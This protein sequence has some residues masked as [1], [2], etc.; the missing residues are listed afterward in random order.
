VVKNDDLR[1]YMDTSDEWIFTRTGVK[2]RRY[3]EV[4]V[5]T[6]DLALEASRMAIKD[7]GLA[8]GD[9]ECIVLATL[10]PDRLFPGTAIYLQNKLG[11]ADKCCACYDIRQQCSGFVYGTE[12]ARAFI[13]GGMYR[14]VLVVGAEVHSHMLDFSTRGRNVT[15]LFGDGASAT[16]FQA[17]DTDKLDEGVFYTEAHAD[18]NGAFTGVHL[19]GYDISHKPILDYD[20]LDFNKNE[21]LWPQMPNARNL[22][23]NG[24]IRMAEVALSA[25]EKNGLTIDDVTWVLP[26]QANIHINNE[27]A[28]RLN[29]P[30]EKMLMNMHKYG[31]TTAATIPLLL[32]EHIRSGQI[33][34]GDLLVFVAFGSGFTWGSALVRY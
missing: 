13:E 17:T 14:N 23:V 31:N 22:F 26:H 32:D 24:I 12:M 6:S 27:M 15:V 7:A 25:L 21:T 9:V 19:V 8:P 28:N 10:S 16:L 3:A 1:Q 2:E 4:G 5:Y 30:K 18:G 20:P 11:I 34:R 33:K 29:L